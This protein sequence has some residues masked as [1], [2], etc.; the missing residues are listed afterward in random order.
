MLILIAG[1]SGNLGSRLALNANSRGISVRGLG[2]NASKVNANKTGPLE[3]FVQSSSYYDIAALD[4]A[5]A[6]VDAVICA[7]TAS[8]IM[9]LEGHI[10]LFRAA[11]RAGVKIFLA[12]SW[13]HPWTNIN[14]GEYEHYDTHIAFEHQVAMTSSIRPV[15]MHTGG[16][17]DLLFTP[18]GAGGFDTSGPSPVMNYWGDGNTRKCHWAVLEDVAPWTIDIL[19]RKDVQEGKGGFFQMH[20][21]AS[22]IEELAAVYQKVTGTNVDVVR[23]GSLEELEA[24]VANDRKEKGRSRYIEYMADAGALLTAKGKFVMADLTVTEN[25]K[26]FTTMEEYVEELQKDK[27]GNAAYLKGILDEH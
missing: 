18:Y 1:V 9:D 13:G 26:K 27:E 3:S 11:E 15:Y 10:L 17:A 19:L 8:P 7:Y 5:V 16:F 22:T 25:P 14:Y 23:S 2:R 4:K 20:S 12:S 24:K 6:G 21:G